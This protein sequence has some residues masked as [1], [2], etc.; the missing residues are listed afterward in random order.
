M[1][2]LIWFIKYIDKVSDF[3][4]QLTFKKLSLVEFWDDIKEQYPQLSEKAV[5]VLF[6]FQLCI[7]VRSD[8][9]DILQPKQH[10]TVD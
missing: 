3:T 2:L 8:F 7:F 9:V 4:W 6:L 1:T 10:S 5:T